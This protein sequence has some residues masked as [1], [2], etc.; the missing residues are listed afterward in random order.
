[1]SEQGSAASPIFLGL[2]Q[3]YQ[4][5]ALIHLGKMIHPESQKLERNLEAA[6][7]TIDILGTL[8]QK[9]KGNLAPEE[10]RFLQQVLTNLRLNYV[11]ES[12][13]KEETTDEKSEEGRAEERGTSEGES[14]KKDS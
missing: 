14:G 2:V 1:M 13:R 5:M 7:A 4:F 10:D 8:E 11:D 3:Q 12:K 9:T 6:K